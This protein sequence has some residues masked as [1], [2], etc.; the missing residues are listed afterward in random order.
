MTQKT[1]AKRE[2]EGYITAYKSFDEIL[3]EFFDY[4]PENVEAREESRNHLYN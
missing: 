1:Y 4:L 3:D 2:L